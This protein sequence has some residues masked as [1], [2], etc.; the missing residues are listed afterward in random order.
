[1]EGKI[2]DTL[3]FEPEPSETNRDQEHLGD[4]TAAISLDLAG[5][6]MVNGTLTVGSGVTVFLTRPTIDC[7]VRTPLAHCGVAT[8]GELTPSVA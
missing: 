4:P 1:M 8:A 5:V 2:D 6:L 3:S 7:R